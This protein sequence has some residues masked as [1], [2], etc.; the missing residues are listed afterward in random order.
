MDISKTIH[1]KQLKELEATYN[2]ICDA[3]EAGTLEVTSGELIWSD[4]IDCK[5]L[6]KP[7]G[8]TWRLHCE[9]YHGTG[10]AWE[11]MADG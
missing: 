4:N 6:H 1:I 5:L 7:T 10:G 11:P 9:T 8:L 3:V 2:A